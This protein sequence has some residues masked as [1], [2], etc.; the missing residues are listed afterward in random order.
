LGAK[1]EFRYRYGLFWW[2]WNKRRMR[3]NGLV[4]LLGRSFDGGIWTGGIVKWD[5]GSRGGRSRF[6]EK[7]KDSYLVVMVRFECRVSV[8]RSKLVDD[9]MGAP[10]RIF[11]CRRGISRRS[12]KKV[13]GLWEEFI[14][15]HCIKGTL[16]YGG[17][18]ELS[19]GEGEMDDLPI[20]SDGHDGN[21]KGV[22][23][24]DNMR[25]RV[26]EEVCGERSENGVDEG[27]KEKRVKGVSCEWE[28]DYH[29]DSSCTIF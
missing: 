27:G 14:G 16:F 23:V 19:V 22:R 9:S 26:N 15:E 12:R 8:E 4:P 18:D 25:E 10:E 20:P 5:L 28:L 21:R 2:K 1:D 7:G 29:S 6:F 24:V 13:L 11:V 17:L 3:V